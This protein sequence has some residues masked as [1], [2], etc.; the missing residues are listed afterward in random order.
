[1]KRRQ[2]SVPEQWLVTDERFGAGLLKA[3]RTLPPGSGILVRHHH[4]TVPERSRLLRQIRQAARLRK[5]VV[6]DEAKGRVARVHD[7]AE[8]RQAGLS[9][10]AL[11]FLSPLYL[12]Q[13]HPAWRPLPRMRAAALVRLAR[14]P[15]IALGGMNAVR[16]RRIR[17]LGFAGWAA[18]DGWRLKSLKSLG[19]APKTR[20]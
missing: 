16:F 5:L 9:G 18:I 8:M 6:V 7:S 13:S 20:P 14:V 3:I 19:Q 12:T 15:V 4:L 11:I 17:G 2:S 1:M 10:A